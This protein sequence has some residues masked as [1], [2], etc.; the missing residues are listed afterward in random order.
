MLLTLEALI[1]E[2]M[3]IIHVQSCLSLLYAVMSP[4]LVMVRLR[5]RSCKASN[6]SNINLSEMKLGTDSSLSVMIVAYIL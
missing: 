2:K 1:Q 4:R 6:V 3:E 5:D